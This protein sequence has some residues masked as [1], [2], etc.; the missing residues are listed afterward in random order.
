MIFQT[1]RTCPE[2]DFLIL[3]KR[4]QNIEKKLILID[5]KRRQFPE[6]VWVGITAENREMFWERSKIFFNCTYV[7]QRKRFVSF[8]PLIEDI[9]PENILPLNNFENI[10]IDRL[11][12]KFYQWFIVGGET[13]PGARPMNL[14]W[15]RKIR[16]E[17]KKAGNPFFFKKAGSG[18]ETPDDLNIREFP[19]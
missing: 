15:A 6:N 17:A 11:F 3:T 8:E 14:D 7:D 1:I 4:P 10:M 5:E 19:E 12:K 16:D 13:G 9:L 18:Q 2:K